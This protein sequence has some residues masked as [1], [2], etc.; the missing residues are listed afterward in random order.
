MKSMNALLLTIVF[1]CLAFTVMMFFPDLL[2]AQDPPPPAFGPGPSQTPVDGGL[3]LLAAGGAG[4]AIKKLR[5]RKR[6]D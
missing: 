3:A 1:V 6:T 4:Y 2:L 5:D